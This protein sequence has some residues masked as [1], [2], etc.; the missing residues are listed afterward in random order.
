MRT[1]LINQNPI[2]SR[3]SGLSGWKSGI[4]IVEKSSIE[5]M[6]SDTFD[7]LF[8]DDALLEGM[9][10]EELKAAGGIRK[11]CL[12]YADDEVK[13]PGFDYYIKKPFLPTEM[14]DLLNEIK[15]DLLLPEIEEEIEHSE[16]MV[17]AEEISGLEAQESFEGFENFLNEIEAKENES[18]REE[19][20]EAAAAGE[21]EGFEVSFEEMDVGERAFSSDKPLPETVEDE[22]IEASRERVDPKE[23]E[24]EPVSLPEPEEPFAGVLD[25]DLVSEVKELLEDGAESEEEE[26]P[27]ISEE[28]PEEVCTEEE[29]EATQSAK[30]EKMENG[31][32]EEYEAVAVAA[33]IPGDEFGLVSKEELGAV[34]G[35]TF[36][37][38]ETSDIRESVRMRE[39]EADKGLKSG[40]A[41]LISRLLG[42]S[43]E[44]LRKLLA[45]AQVTINITFPKES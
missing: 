13:I 15:D 7:L 10:P 42:M 1:L 8:I 24:A 29:T 4:D 25:E 23:E 9:T 20:R 26:I 18:R 38:E 17:Q 44:A 27:K 37:H 21:E 14:V 40:E 11:V 30:E 28:L 34:A 35:E 16:E 22:D 32:Y 19:E 43:P 6:E 39:E 36:S 41:A 33:E 2:V 31:F 3:L 5:E 45:G 12:I